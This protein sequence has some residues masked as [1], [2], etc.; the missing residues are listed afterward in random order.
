MSH[1]SDRA[2]RPRRASL[3]LALCALSL[4]AFAQD[5]AS[6]EDIGVGTSGKLLLTGGVSQLEGAAGGGLTPWAVIGGNGTRD[7]IGANAF[8]TRVT[9]GDYH[10]D[11][12]GAMIGIRDRVEIS[13]AQQRFDT[14]DV[15]AALGLGQGYTFQQNVLGVKV[16][17]AGEAVLDSDS[18]MPQISVGLQYKKNNRSGVLAFIG[19]ESDSGTDLYVSATKLYLGQGLLLNGT[20]R[21]TKAN[22]IGI[23]GFGGDRNDSY[24]PQLE[25]SAAWL[26]SRKVAIGAE[27]RM[28]P[29]NLGIAKEDDWYDLFVAYAPNKNVSL[30]LA[31][32]DLGN[33]VIKDNQRG[34]Y[35]SLQVGF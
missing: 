19:A 35:A 10:L 27:Y 7:Q 29:D 4:P 23:L 8:Y 34:F 14:E 11:D 2:T 9:V 3:F 12:Y 1:R 18:A 24:K 26:L 16:R 33:I 25:L 5:A 31:Y 32:A 22:Q 28:K 30:T 13:L 20:L 6:E 21:F 15:G 17:V